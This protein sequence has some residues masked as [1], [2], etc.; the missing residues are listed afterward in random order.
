[1]NK[2]QQLLIKNIR[3]NLEK[4]AGETD[5]IAHEEVYRFLHSIKGT[6]ATI[7]LDKASEIAE[8][9]MEQLN[10]KEDR[11]WKKDELQSFLHPL[12]S[13]F[14][15]EGYQSLVSQGNKSQNT[16][17][18]GLVL[19]FEEDP[20]I[21]MQLK[22]LLGEKGYVVIAV[23]DSTQIHS[24]YYEFKPKAVLISGNL[25]KKQEWADLKDVR[26]NAYREFI[27]LLIL[28]KEDTTESRIEQYEKGADDVISN[29][30]NV[31]E[32]SVRVERLLEHKK[33]I[34]Q[35]MVLDE[36]TRVY[37]RKQ[38]TS[39]YNQLKEQLEKNKETF[40][41]IMI[42]I[43]RFKEIND[44]Y[45]HLAGDKVL[46][47][48][49]KL[50]KENLRSFDTIIR[51]GGEEFLMLLPNT[52]AEQARNIIER[53]L[54]NFQKI[55]YSVENYSPFSCTFS[56]GVQE[57]TNVTLS[58]KENLDLADQAL[59]KAKE[60]G[61]SLV[62]TSKDA[63]NITLKKRISIGIV[64]DDPII[65]SMLSEQITKSKLTKIYNIEIE[66]FKNGQVF[67]DSDW[68]ERKASYLILLDGMMPEMDG[69]EVLERLRKRPD[70][71]RF[72]ILMLT[73]RKSEKDIS[74]AIQLGADDYLT[75]PFKLL[76][77]EIRI[78]YLL[79]RM[80]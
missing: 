45:G 2:Y 8:K 27:P 30:I 4:W 57:V 55:T 62:L 7:G 18:A 70:Q 71:S 44:T 37:N 46:E 25:E 64:D 15:Y 65:L 52:S 49:A 75:K 22:D 43:D 35:R 11:L 61:R 53:I 41:M 48:L 26:K 79:Q 16:F 73:S 3:I 50:L 59:Y 36:L 60:A 5:S 40:S 39:S 32:L 31:E 10:E 33:R 56:A 72:T 68:K 69:L 12:I 34:D 58:L 38:L 6:A 24:S 21:I 13:L 19:L 42:D 14:Y 66:T 9:L 80:K 20:E 63:Q 47:S 76:E 74:R 51:Y 54:D 23:T 28:D 67:M 1:M 17:D 77:L 78:R 29:G